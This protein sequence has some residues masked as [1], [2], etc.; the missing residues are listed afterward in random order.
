MIPGFIHNEPWVNFAH[1]RNQA[2]QL[3]KD[4]ASSD[5]LLIIDADDT[6]EIDNSHEWPSTAPAYNITV[7]HG[8]LNYRKTHFLRLDSDF[9]YEGPTH[10]VLVSHSNSMI[11]PLNGI[12]YRCNGDG[13]HS[14]DPLKFLKDA[15]LLEEY[16]Q[17]HPT[18][19]RW[20]FYLANSYR[21][22]AL[23]ANLSDTDRQRYLRL[24]YEYYSRRIDLG[25]FPEEVFIAMLEKAKTSI[26]IQPKELATNLYLFL[27]AWENRSNRAEP[28]VELCI[29]LRNE[30]RIKMAYPFAKIANEIPFPSFELL[31]V[32]TEDYS[33]RRYDELAVTAYYVENYMLSKVLNEQLL[34]KGLLPTNQIDRIKDNLQHAEI[35]LKEQYAIKLQRKEDTTSIS[36]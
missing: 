13:A 4:Y 23:D 7:R 29:Y 15:W 21:D 34:S 19:G 22:Y 3:A 32:N 2:I 12:Y 26:R 18:D 25:G 31:F 33:W 27:Q 10:E 5:Y 17:Q 14:K 30:G 1:N 9:Q 36:E 6:L 28:L 35:K 24:A 8:N 11:E 20:F 16:I